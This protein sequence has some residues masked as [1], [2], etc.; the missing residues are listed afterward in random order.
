MQEVASKEADLKR[1][2]FVKRLNLKI[3]K[4]SNVVHGNMKLVKRKKVNRQST[5]R[6]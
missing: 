3:N 5:N 1:F 6:K 2:I 4:H